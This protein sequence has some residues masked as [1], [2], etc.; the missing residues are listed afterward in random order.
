[1]N[2][3][4][5]RCFF[6]VILFS[7]PSLCF[8]EPDSNIWEFLEENFYYNKTNVTKSSNIISIWT[9]GV[10]TDNFRNARIEAVK[11]EDIEKSEAYKSF[12]HFLGLCEIDCGK[13]QC[14]G[15]E[16]IDYDDQGNVL[17]HLKINNSEW[18][19]ITPYSIFDTLYLK[20]CPTEKKQPQKN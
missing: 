13:K 7:I 2:S 3:K 19:I 1:M 10:V 14:R 4:I 5:L 8:S 6:L 18:E 15:T 16:F 20:L 12:D 17:N 9:Y 11:K